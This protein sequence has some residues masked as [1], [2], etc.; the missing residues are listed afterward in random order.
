[1][2]STTNKEKWWIY[3]IFLFI[4]ILSLFI[5]FSA[6]GLLVILLTFPICSFLLHLTI[7]YYGTE[8]YSPAFVFAT[9][10]ASIIIFLIGFIGGTF[11]QV[12]YFGSFGPFFLLLILFATG[13]I[14]FKNDR[15]TK[16]ALTAFTISFAT[17]F[18]IFGATFALAGYHHNNST[19]ISAQL[20]QTAP[21]EFVVLTEQDLNEYPEIRDAITNKGTIKVKLDEWEL[22]RNFLDEKGSYTVKFGDDYYEIGFSSA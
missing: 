21:D 18:L 3:L 1:M 13:S 8:E 11:L 2:N 4:G 14:I 7:K 20:L 15:H 6:G 5:G 16:F 17:I 10:A 12:E 22:I 19:G 9:L